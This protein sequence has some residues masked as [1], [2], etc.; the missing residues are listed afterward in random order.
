MGWIE[1]RDAT[2]GKLEYSVSG[3]GTISTTQPAKENA[4]QDTPY[5]VENYK[6]GVYHG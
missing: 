1:V 4:K 3:D 6:E 5:S 2:T